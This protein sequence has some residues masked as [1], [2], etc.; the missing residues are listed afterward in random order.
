MSW[1]TLWKAI[2]DREWQVI[3]GEWLSHL[4]TKMAVCSRPDPPLSQLVNLSDHFR[5]I[6]EP[7]L[8]EDVPGIRR[9]AFAEALFLF[10]K[11]LHVLRAAQRH[12][13]EGMPSWSLFSAYHSAYL[14]TR[15]VMYLLGV[16][17][18][19]VDGKQ[20]IIDLFPQIKLKHTRGK[21][22]LGAGDFENIKVIPSPK[23]EQ[24]YFWGTFQRIVRLAKVP[25]WDEKLVSCI[26]GLSWERI[27]PA[28]NRFI[29]N[30]IFWPFDDLI[31]GLP[32]DLVMELASEEDLEPDR[33][34]FLFSLAF[35]TAAMAE[36]LMFDLGKIAPV[37]TGELERAGYVGPEWRTAN[38]LYVKFL[39]ARNLDG[40]RT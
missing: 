34:S 13:N 31:D 32:S 33:L 40:I 30:P 1:E 12:A 2:L 9:A 28:R 25:V 14:T 11:G 5:G 15:S 16:T 22:T 26:L 4:P 20:Y 27:S 37:I 39:Y 35:R 21:R 8:I 17:F 3:R 24:R 23:I 7:T 10:H 29:Y 38:S 19:L 18:P 6:N 36:G